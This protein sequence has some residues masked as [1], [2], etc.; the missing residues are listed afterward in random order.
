MVISS[1]KESSSSKRNFSCPSS[2]G[3]LLLADEEVF[4]RPLPEPPPVRV[5]EDALPFEV[6]TGLPAR[7]AAALSLA[8]AT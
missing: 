8:F 3:A 6:G 5:P 7:L 1:F 2:L 4:P